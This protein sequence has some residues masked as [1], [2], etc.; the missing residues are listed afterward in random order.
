M[1]NVSGYLHSVET[2]GTL[3]GPGIRRILFLNGCPLKCVY[4]HNPDSRKFKGG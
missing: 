3:D 2:A 1:D 4:C